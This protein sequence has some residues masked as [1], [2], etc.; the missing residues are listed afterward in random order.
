LS[1]L[2]RLVNRPDLDVEEIRKRRIFSILT[3]PGI[4][5]IFPFSFSHLFHNNWIE[6]FADLATG[7][8]LCMILIGFKTMASSRNIFRI[9][10]V[11]I[12]CLFVYLVVKGGV[13]GNK[14]LWIFSYPPIAF[15]SLGKKEGSLSTV[16]L[17]L[18]IIALLYQPL[19]V[20]IPVHVYAPEFKLR[21]C[22]AFL[23]VSVWTF[24]Y[25][26]VREQFQAN[27]EDERNKLKVEKAKLS[28]LSATLGDLNRAL[29]QSEQ[30]MIQAQ[31]LA[32]VGNLEYDFT[33][34]MVWGSEEA[35]RILGVDT[36][37]SVFPLSILAQIIP[38]FEEFRLEFEDCMRNN[39][40]FDRELLIHR[41]V[42]RRT[43]V[44]YGKAEV[45]R[46]AAGGAEK[47]IGVIQD[48]TERKEAEREKRLL[49]EKLA[50]SQKMEALGLLAGGVA[51]DLN[52]VLSGIVGY[53]DLLL[54]DLGEKHPMTVPL[55]RI[56]ESGQKAAAIVQ[57]LLTLARR[58]VANHQVINLNKLV[59]EYMASPEHNDL[60]MRYADVA[61][62][63]HL[64]PSLLNING[65]AMHLMKAIDNLVANAA[66]ALPAGGHVRI[67]TE[68]RYVDK[69]AKGFSDVP[70]GEYA[71]LLV[72]DDGIGI[73]REDLGRI[74]EPFYT[75]KK[76]GRS[77]TGL[78]MAVI[79]GTAKDHH[80]HIHIDS[81]EGRGT[82]IILYFPATR[83]S[84]EDSPQYIPLE[85]YLGKGERILVVDDVAEQREL[86]GS[87]LTKLGYRVDTVGGGE[88]A[89]DFL[90]D[91][92][93]QLV[94][95]DMIM[96]P[97]I[98]GLETYTRI[99]AARPDQRTIIVSG[100][101]ETDRVREAQRLGVSAYIKK[102]YTLEKL[103]VAVRK[104]LTVRHFK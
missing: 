90:S 86:A 91:H 71:A 41:L 61:V 21:F 72:E 38:N 10:A 23:L 5:I 12:G 43:V 6:G 79:W 69:V 15:Y 93:V 24:L 20:N 81:E 36:S 51:H 17:F 66:E 50:R 74:F 92:T 45:V 26:L 62:E 80:G 11:I 34:G 9:N 83:E 95:L 84:E 57:D 49:E 35:L 1:I 32:R 44:L 87:M 13:Q 85:D 30:R 8:W 64:D 42:D 82:R 75:K 104:A 68:N 59:D 40:E 97:G 14:L 94:I 54:R 98:D 55:Q 28:E 3:L 29:L 25:E 78:G 96:D 2:D 31:A 18:F 65:S 89:L 52:N 48:I 103:G 99:L 73:A 27:L 88:A 53:P 100:F 7:V 4:L 39:R 67:G 46:N 77:G 76:M 60:V 47:T 19:P 33:T 22:M 58:G 102:P 16:L 70:E 101:S 37:T 63:A 56:R